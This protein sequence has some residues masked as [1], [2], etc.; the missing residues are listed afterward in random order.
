[1]I[2]GIIFDLDGTLLDTVADIN[3]ELNKALNKFGFNSIDFEETKKFL[4]NGSRTLVKESLKK[5]V[6]NKVLDEVANYYITNYSNPKANVLTKPY[7]GIIE[8]LEVLQQMGIKTAITS[9]KMDLAVK[10]L[11][12]TAFNGLFDIALGESDKTPLKPDP[13]ML[14]QALDLMNLR[15]EE[16]LFIGDT[17][18]DLQAATNASLNSVAVTWGFRSK[19]FLISLKPNYII[20]EPN[21]LINIIKI[22]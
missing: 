21:E 1:M 16:V 13:T 4:G 7:E 22:G 8:M 14:Y 11:N 5:T 19:D 2:K 18:V 3:R 12:E 6:D 17:E 9:N 10:E 20:D 15:K